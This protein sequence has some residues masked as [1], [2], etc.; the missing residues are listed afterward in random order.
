MSTRSVGEETHGG[1]A[2]SAVVGERS[3]S[4]AHRARSLESRISN[5]M[6][7]GVMGLLGLG[8]LT[9]YYGSALT[10]A[11]RAARATAA[12][13][14]AHA[15]PDAPLPPLGRIRWADHMAHKA[16]EPE[17]TLERLM[18]Q[19]AA[20]APTAGSSTAPTALSAMPPQPVQPSAMARRL[21]G[22]PFA[23]QMQ[24]PTGAGGAAIGEQLD[25]AT[26][27]NA[28]PVA[29]AVSDAGQRSR[30]GRGG[31]IT[32]LLKP[33]VT[34]AVSA[35][36]LPT[37]RYLLPK[38]AFVDCTLETAID[39]T[40]PGMTTCITATDTFSVDGSVVLLERGSKLVGETRGQVQQGS[41]RVFVVWTEVRTPTGVVVPLDSP[42]TD[43]LGRAGLAGQVDRHFWDRFGA[44]ILISVIDSGTQAATRPSGGTF[45]YSPTAS[46]DVMTEV[47]KGTIDI[48]P[49]VIKNQGDRIQ[50]LVARDLDFRSVYELRP[51]DERR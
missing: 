30:T 29:A 10:R 23:R 42:G 28:S 19:T 50:V 18:P 22:P 49:S 51:L 12:A 15:Q 1:G 6:A 14:V 36:A 11:P 24:A 47:L 46:Q 48:P 31:E 8:V 44:A 43:E 2:A 3:V 4:L 37:Q 13:G 9:W 27:G 40:L 38:G 7:V 34:A 45:I 16:D 39:S 32:E 35:R 26:A 21:S 25:P 17:H 33:A 5:L 41:A 20:L